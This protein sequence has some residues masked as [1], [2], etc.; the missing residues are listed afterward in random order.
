MAKKKLRVE[1]W[2]KEELG[3]PKSVVRV[4]QRRLEEA[5]KIAPSRLKRSPSHLLEE[6]LRLWWLARRRELFGRGLSRMVQDPQAMAIERQ[7]NREFAVCD[8]DGLERT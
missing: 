8:D 6:G 3:E 5:L 7:L 4:S 2:P 1:R